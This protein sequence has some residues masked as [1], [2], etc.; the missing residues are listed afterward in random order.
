MITPES[1]SLILSLVFFLIAAGMLACA[2]RMKVGD[3]TLEALKAALQDGRVTPDE[4]AGILQCYFREL[5]LA[6]TESKEK[7]K[8]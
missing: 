8:E 6:G 2:N 3:G 7:K 1:F 5:Y 4:A